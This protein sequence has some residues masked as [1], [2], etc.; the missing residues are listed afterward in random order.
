MAKRKQ[1]SD[2]AM[3]G[4]VIGMSIGV[5]LGAGFGNPGLGVATVLSNLYLYHFI[6]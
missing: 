5:A 2:P 4:M 6:C 3:A 1:P